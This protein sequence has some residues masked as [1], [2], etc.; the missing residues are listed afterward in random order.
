MLHQQQ[1]VNQTLL[2]VIQYL[3]RRLEEPRTDDPHLR[4]SFDVGNLISAIQAV[5][6]AARQEEQ[7]IH[8]WQQDGGFASPA[9][10]TTASAFEST[11]PPNAMVHTCVC[12]PQGA[13]SAF[14]LEASNI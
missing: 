5:G 11:P 10:F 7:V 13:K 14:Q 3:M 1:T 2:K 9:V 12:R 8:K 6:N 4:P